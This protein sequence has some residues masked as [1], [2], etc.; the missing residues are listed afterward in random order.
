[1]SFLHVSDPHDENP[2]DKLR[3]VRWLL[4]HMKETCKSLFQPHQKVSVDE[5]MVKMKGRSCLRQYMPQKPIKWGIKLFA[6]CDVL[7]SYLFDF[8]VYTGAVPGQVEEGLT[9]AVVQSLMT[10]YHE[11]GYVVYTDNFYT[12]PALANALTARGVELVGTLRA[13]RVG[14]PASLKD[15]KHFERNAPRGDMRYVRSNGLLFIQWVD[16]RVVTMLST[17]HKA[18]DNLMIQRNTKQQGQH[19]VIHIKQQK[20]VSDYNGGMGGVDVFDQRCATFKVRR[21]SRKFW[22]ALFFDFLEVASVNSY[23]LF[24]EYR[25]LNPDAILRKRSYSHEDFR[26]AIIQQLGQCPP[27]APVPIYQNPGAPERPKPP[28]HL[29]Q[30]MDIRRNCVY[31]WRQERTERKCQVKC[32]TCNVFLHVERRDCFRLYHIEH[33]M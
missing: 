11:Q 1:M 22:K 19:A 12:S 9:S 14:T 20:A 5:R 13:N 17:Y 2:D 33:V 18:T 7:T 16:K 27:H 10:D 31:C 28:T 24:S 32:D 29:P 3:K 4:D 26:I 8:N 23:I 21:K 30:A 25:R 15:T 6:A